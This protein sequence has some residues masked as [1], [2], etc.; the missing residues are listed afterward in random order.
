MGGVGLTAVMNPAQLAPRDQIK[1]LQNCI[2]A[3][4]V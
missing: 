2:D 3:L 1:I 4:R